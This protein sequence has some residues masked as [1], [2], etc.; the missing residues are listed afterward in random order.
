MKT[1]A[2]FNAM[3]IG[4]ILL[5]AGNSMAGD[6]K[7]AESIVLNGGSLGSVT[8]THGIHQGMFADC[9]P[10]HELFPKES[11]VVDKMKAEGKLQRRDVMN[12]CKKCHKD[13]ADKGKKTG[14][15]NCKDCHKK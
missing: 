10:C 11:Q 12:M 3:I 6:N 7:G 2:L 14:P 15:T 13:L 9:K 5:S 1:G 4:G 8:F